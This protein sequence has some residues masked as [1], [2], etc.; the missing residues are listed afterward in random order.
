MKSISARTTVTATLT[1]F[2]LAAGWAQAG[3][4]GVIRGKVIF[5]GD[6]AAHKRQVLDTSKDP[7]CKK[8]KAKIGSEGTILNKKTDPITLRNVLVSV[9]DGLGDRTYAP[10]AQPVVLDQVGCQYKPHVL[11]MMEGQ[12]IEIRNGDAT[13]HN[14]HFLP[15][16]NDEYNKTQPK[17]G[18]KDRIKLVAEAPFRVKCDVHP[19]MGCYIGVFKHPFFAVT[20]KDGTFELKG[21]PAGTYTVSAWHET[22]GEQTAQVVVAV[23]EVKEHDFTFEPGK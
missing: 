17:K 10:P 8:A 20:G 4:N 7:A 1:V 2:C 9:S 15:K 19:W 14:I 3:D 21:L 12:E 23:D 16:I 6:P 18:M 11:G 13:N 22:F 5:K